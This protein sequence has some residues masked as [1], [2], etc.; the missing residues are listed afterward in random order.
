LLVK[1]EHLITTRTARYYKL[2]EINGR[3]RNVWL[4]LHGHKQLAGNFIKE[5]QELASNCDVVFAAEALLRFYTSGD[6]GNVGAT[7]MTKEDRLSDITDYVNYLDKLF[8]KEIKPCKEK[9]SFKIN[10]LGFSQGAATLSRWLVLGKSKVDKAIFWCG[11][12]AN[13]VDYKK[14]D[15]FK[16]TEIHLVFANNDPYFPGEF[17]KTQETMLEQN[18]ITP[19]VHIFEGS[20]EIS[21]KLMGEMG[22]ISRSE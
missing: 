12:L 9:F 8:D 7:W 1:E 11:N 20:H 6:Y 3:T 19:I 21:V 14:S 2:G 13:D 18:S 10:A 5:F 17:Y 22:I 4:L 15:S 16:S